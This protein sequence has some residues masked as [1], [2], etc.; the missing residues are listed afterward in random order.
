[1]MIP[2]RDSLKTQI[3]S[4][5]LQHNKSIEPNNVQEI[6]SSTIDHLNPNP[7][8]YSIGIAVILSKTRGVRKMIV[9]MIVE[10]ELV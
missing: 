3:N 5:L 6:A 2:P 10:S 1:M 7:N 4:S 8:W 9:K